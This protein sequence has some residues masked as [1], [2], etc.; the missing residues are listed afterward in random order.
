[1][2]PAQTSI[3][4]ITLTVKDLGRVLD[5]YEGSLGLIKQKQEGSK[6]TLGASNNGPALVVLEEHTDAQKRPLRAPG[7]FHTAFLFPNRKELARILQRLVQGGVTFQGFADHLVSEALYLADPEGNGVELY[8]DRARELWKWAG[9]SV[10]MA[11]NALDL[12]HLMAELNGEESIWTGTPPDLRIGHIH[13][14][15]SGLQQAEDFWARRVGFDVV[16]R[17]YPGA[18][19]V[20]AGGY[21]HHLGLNIWNSSRMSLPEGVMT[22]LQSLKIRLPDAGSLAELGIQLQAPVV[23][24]AMTVKDQDGITVEFEAT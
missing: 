9:S 13:L 21:H 16:Q 14:Q 11:T 22:G 23:E 20:S 5:F 10:E 15:V 17:E 1:M 6:I 3:G 4:S 24:D 8:A 12:E 18:L 2:L 19:F 7:L